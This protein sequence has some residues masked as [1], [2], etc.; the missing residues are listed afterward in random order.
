[1]FM[2][3][4]LIVEDEII[5]ARELEARLEGMGYNVVG[6]AS[7]GDEAIR[8]ATDCNPDLVLMDI[9]IK[10]HM[11]GIDA[12]ERIR[13]QLGVPVIYVTAYTDDKTLER[14]RV[15]E[16]FAYLVKPFSERELK[17]NIEMAL[18]KHKMEQRLRK[19]ER[20]LTESVDELTHAVIASD[21]EGRITFFNQGAEAIT[22][23]A[24]EDAIGRPV[25]EV[26]RLI[27]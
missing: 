27:D 23:W 13:E 11:D 7:S 1:M 25:D 21:L 19:V 18:Y 14:A 9:V 10:G 22:A 20:W 8:F 3:R 12:A 24:R 17:A 4:I 15:T 6:I 26:F 16:P 2:S 5:I